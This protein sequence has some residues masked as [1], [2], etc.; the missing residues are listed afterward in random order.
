MVALFAFS[1]S[2][3]AQTLPNPVVRAL[4][5]EREWFDGFSV[6]WWKTVGVEPYA[7]Q[8][9]DSSK[10]TV[11]ENLVEDVRILAIA[12]EEFQEDENTENYPS[13]QLNITLAG[14]QTNIG[15]IYSLT[16]PKG[17]LNINVDGTWVPNDKVTYSFTLKEG[18]QYEVPAPTISPAQ[19]EVDV[20]ETV[21][22]S[23]EG[24]AVRRQTDGLGGYSQQISLSFND[25][26]PENVTSTPVGEVDPALSLH[27]PA[28][29][30]NINAKKNGRYVIT[31]PAGTF[32]IANEM[33]GTIY[34]DEPII[35]T[36]DFTGESD[37]TPDYIPVEPVADPAD[38]YVGGPVGT[39]AVTWPG[40]RLAMES[41]DK[42]ELTDVNPGFIDV[43]VNGSPIVFQPSEFGGGSI[44][45]KAQYESD[46]STTEQ[47]VDDQLVINLPDAFFNWVG[48]VKIVIKEGAVKSVDG[49]INSAITLNYKFVELDYNAVWEPEESPAA[50]VRFDEGE[51]I[52]YAYWEGY[53]DPELNENVAPF[54]Q[55]AND[56]GNG[57]QMAATDYVSMVGNKVKF[58][59]S[60]FV[61]GTY[62]LVIPDAAVILSPMVYNGEAVYEFIIGDE[63][64]DE[65]GD[66]EPGDDEPGDNPGGEEPGDN[67]GGD[68]PGDN[69]GGDEP[70]DSG[71]YGVYSDS[72]VTVYNLQ[73]I[74]LLECADA[75]ALSTLPAGL[76]IVNGKKILLP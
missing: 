5:S 65:P 53:D 70:D 34:I 68:E 14:F 38:N 66:D 9:V 19:G 3:A 24:F 11:E 31:M 72:V 64:G 51:C 29:A 1:F 62:T 45:V 35:L 32:M 20:L 16:I 30:L 63:N 21:T 8:I 25:G 44:G 76:Y 33:S 26:E 52:I 13:G 48:D 4:P 75:E 61:P 36:Y 40:V 12:I 74:R 41:Q 22:L 73:G 60:T 10:I 54:Y 67:P 50:P 15:S 37:E 56:E 47:R 49:E 42:D 59:F 43:V 28:V 17:A 6:I 46:G 23:W 39:V 55:L 7:I 58:D 27:Y 71:V 57:P 18:S 69:P 2:A